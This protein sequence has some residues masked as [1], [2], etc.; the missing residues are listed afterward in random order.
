MPKVT[1]IGDEEENTCNPGY[2]CCP[3]HRVG[4]NATGSPNV[5]V[6]GKKVHRVNDTGPTN[7]PH[8][9]TFESISGSPNVFVNGKPVTRI[10][11]STKCKK[12]GLV[13]KHISGSPDVIV[14]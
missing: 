9:G 12:C 13:G 8:G 14:N 7:C 10:G 2:D 11:D 3:H 1:R 5:F 6:N 4:T